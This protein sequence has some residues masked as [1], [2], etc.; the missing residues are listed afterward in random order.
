[1]A[2]D[3]YY[4]YHNDRFWGTLYDVG[5]TDEQIAP[6]EYR[7]LGDEY[8]IYL[9]EVVDPADYRVGKDSEIEPQQVREGLATLEARIDTHEP[10]RLAF[11]GKNAATWFYRHLQDKEITHSQASGHKNDRRNLE[12]P[13][14]GFD[15]KGVDYFLL[16]NTHRHWDQDMWESFW[17]RC[18]ADLAAFRE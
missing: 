10:T 9:T 5:L 4:I 11:V 13:E 12:G 16:S 15:H 2:E 18:R 8:G 7:R 6:A 14:L 17:K 1:M 3:A